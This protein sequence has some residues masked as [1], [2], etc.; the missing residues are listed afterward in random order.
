MGRYVAG[1]YLGWKA[2][3]RV[4]GGGSTR[5]MRAEIGILVAIGNVLAM[6]TTVSLRVRRHESMLK[7]CRLWQFL[8][9]G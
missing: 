5:S 9:S 2:L 3:D 6:I 7:G 1:T 8:P 4:D